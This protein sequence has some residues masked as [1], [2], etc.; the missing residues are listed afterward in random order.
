[1]HRLHENPKCALVNIP[2]FVASVLFAIMPRD[3]LPKLQR[4]VYA[5][6]I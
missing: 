5:S 3:R 2:K 6:E 4:P 1:M